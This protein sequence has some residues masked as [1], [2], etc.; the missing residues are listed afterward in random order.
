MVGYICEICW[1]DCWEVDWK[2]T[3]YFFWSGIQ[4]WR[5]WNDFGVNKLWFC[6]CGVVLVLTNCGDRIPFGGKEWILL[7]VT[8]IRSVCRILW[9]TVG[10]CWNQNLVFTTDVSGFLGRFPVGYDGK[11]REI[12][13]KCRNYASIFRPRILY[14]CSVDFRR[15]KSWKLCHI[16]PDCSGKCRV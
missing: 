14:S 2:F 12:F 10:N 7:E 13:G 5:F 6:N 4:I 8:G 16:R 15:C 3:R 9:E 1:A 11:V